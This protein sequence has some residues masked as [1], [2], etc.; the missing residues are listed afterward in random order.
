MGEANKEARIEYCR[1]SL[2][3]FTNI[4]AMKIFVRLIWTKVLV[5]P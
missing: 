3:Y 1:L 4:S 5:I 2:K